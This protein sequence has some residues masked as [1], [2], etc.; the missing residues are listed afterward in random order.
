MHALDLWRKQT[1]I[2]AIAPVEEGDVIDQDDEG[3]DILAGV[4]DVVEGVEEHD[5]DTR[6]ASQKLTML[7]NWSNACL[8]KMSMNRNM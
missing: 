4:D 3:N 2:P 6:T 1:T 5:V 8:I 7:R